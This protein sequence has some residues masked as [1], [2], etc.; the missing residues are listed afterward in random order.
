MA[1]MIHGRE[2]H[3]RRTVWATCEIARLCPGRDLARMGE[4]MGEDFTRNME[5]SARIVSILSQADAQA[6]KF[7]MPAEAPPLPLT[8]EELYALDLSEFTALVTEAMSAFNADAE[9]TVATEPVKKTES[10]GDAPA[11]SG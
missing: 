1:T 8:V 5:A 7:E 6:R 3:F 11:Q 4:V 10:G 2:V 9:T